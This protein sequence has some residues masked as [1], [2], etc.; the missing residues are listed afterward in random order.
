MV[1]G[2]TSLHT[3][4][5]GCQIGKEPAHLAAAELPCNTMHMEHIF[6]DIQTDRVNLHHVED[7]SM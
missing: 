5:A 1:R 2:R 6:R 7:P 3:D 4:E